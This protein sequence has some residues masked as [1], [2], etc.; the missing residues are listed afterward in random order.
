MKKPI[1]MILIIALAAFSPFFG[2][3]APPPPTQSFTIT[4]DKNDGAATGTMSPQTI[5]GGA[6]VT[7]PLCEFVKDVSTFAGWAAL[8]TGDVEFGDGARYTMGTADVTLYARWTA[9]SPS[10]YSSPYGTYTCTTALATLVDATRGWNDH[11]TYVPTREV[12]IKVHAPDSTYPG[13]FPLIMVS[14]GLGGDV[15]S[16][17]YMAEDLATHGYIVV[18]VQ[19]H[20]SDSAYLAD[21]GPAALLASANQ[22]ATRL[23]RPQ[24]MT[25]VLNAIT[26]GTTGI[27]LLDVGR[28]NLS[29]VGGVGHSFGAWT[30]L[31]CLGQT[32]DGGTN[33]S[34]SR[35]VCGV[36]YSPQG[37]GTLGL[38]ASSWNALTKPA[39]TLAGTEDTAPGTKDPAE[40]RIPFDS[41]PATGTKYHATLAGATHADFG[42]IENGFYHDWIQ[43][44][45]MAFFDAF[46]RND[47]NAKS[48]LSNETIE[49]LTS[50]VAM[51]RK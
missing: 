48:W 47:S 30:T 18:S 1:S 46:L 11:G 41:M 6:S 23:L 5:A 49:M 16:I 9:N 45:T 43:Q 51:E 15:D 35:F 32:F 25:F 39:F 42:G 2:C 3:S 7:L 21:G 26:A 19:H 36:A 17:S 29:L 34:D 14:H 31:S 28:I 38:D 22:Q 20:G 12:P 27:S 37:P 13:P 8:P 10:P 4:F 40:R 50:Y 24:D 33:A 44:M